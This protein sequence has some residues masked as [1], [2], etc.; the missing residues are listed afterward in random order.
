MTVTAQQIA[1]LDPAELEKMV[2]GK[3][4]DEAK[5]ILEPYGEVEISV[6]PDWSGSVPSFESRVDLTIGQA[7]Q[8][9]TPAPSVSAAP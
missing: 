9:E 8:I 2:L 4:V 7:V 5:A 3:P 6:S 1:I